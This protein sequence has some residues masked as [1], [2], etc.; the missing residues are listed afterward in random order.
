MDQ[1]TQQ[2]A[3]MVEESTTA[4]HALAEEAETL[5]QLT[6]RFQISKEATRQ[7]RAA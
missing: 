5:T 6:A 2:N 4:S 7:R 1:M 3:A